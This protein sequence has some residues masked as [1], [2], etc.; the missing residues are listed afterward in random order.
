M[1]ELL[2]LHARAWALLNRLDLCYEDRELF[3]L[4]NT[5]QSKAGEAPELSFSIGYAHVEENKIFIETD[6]CAS[7]ELAYQSFETAALVEAEK[8]KRKF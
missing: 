7:P 1:Q 3:C 5:R 2:N 8:M 4:I 6:I